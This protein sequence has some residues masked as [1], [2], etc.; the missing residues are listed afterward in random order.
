MGHVG[1][2]DPPEDRQILARLELTC[3]PAPDQLHLGRA[4]TTLGQ[5]PRSVLAR[6]VGVATRVDEHK[7]GYVLGV[8]EGVLQRD[9]AAEGVRSEERRVGKECRG[10]WASD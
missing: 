7:P 3:E 9:V 10:G 8:S 4:V 2:A 6:P 1:A 5:D